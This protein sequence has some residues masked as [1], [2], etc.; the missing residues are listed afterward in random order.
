M[1]PRCLPTAY[2]SGS[3]S[4]TQIQSSWKRAVR[5]AHRRGQPPIT[6]TALNSTAGESS[7][8]VTADKLTLIFTSNRLGNTNLFL[9]TRV[10]ETSPWAAPTR[11]SPLTPGTYESG[12]H[13]SSDGMTLWFT[14][15]ALG[16]FDIF[17]ASRPDIASPF[18]NATVVPELASPES[19]Y[20]AWV[21][22]DRHR[23]YF[24]RAAAIG[25]AL[26][27]VTR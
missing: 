27:M 10:S 23:I 7:P 13:L 9:T 6:L 21:S 12:A 20:E 25:S 22:E 8:T 24:T 26:W 19:D 3:R 4:A 15:N 1:H 11:I 2:R 17:T 16:T 18:G 5:R 14:S